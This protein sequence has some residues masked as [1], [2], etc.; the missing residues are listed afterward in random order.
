VG[1]FSRTPA[2]TH[3]LISPADLPGFDPFNAQALV[4]AAVALQST[5]EETG[6]RAMLPAW[7]RQA[8][9]FYDLLGEC[10]YPAQFYAR[11]LSRV[12]LY[13]GIEQT[14]GEIEED[15]NE[16][17][18]EI[19]A[20]ITGPWTEDYGQLQFLI[21][22]GNL[23][24]SLDDDGE[25]QWEY[26]S[27]AEFKR[28][29]KEKFERYVEPGAN[30]RDLKIVPP[31]AKKIG[32]GQ[33]IAYRLWTRHPMH[34]ALADSPVRAVLPRFQYLMLVDKAADAQA[35]SRIV[36]SGLLVVAEEI[37]L[38]GADSDSDPAGLD[39]DPFM[40]KLARHVMAPITNP[41]SVAQVA[42]FL[43]RI[44]IGDRSIDD[45]IKLIQL[46]DP[47][48]T[49]DWQQRI[50]KCITRIAIGL[51]MPPEEFLGLAEANHWTGW[52][53]SQSKW[54]AH[55]EPKTI[56]LCQDL[57]RV[58]FRK[59][60]R[61]A[62]IENWEKR[63]VWYDDAKV[64]THPDRGKD[65]DAVH[66]RGE[67]SGKSLRAAHDFNEKD[68]PS[69]AERRFF[70]A[71]K[72]KIPARPQDAPEEP[73]SDS[74]S[75]ADTDEPNQRG[76]RTENPSPMNDGQMAAL[77]AAG[78]MALE[79]CRRRAG[80]RV[81]QKR[82]SCEQCFK[83]MDDVPKYDLLARVG[84]DAVRAVGFDTDSGLCSGGAE[85]F[86]PTAMR[87]GLDEKSARLVAGQIEAFARDTLYEDAPVLPSVRL[88][89]AARAV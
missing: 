65:A 33:A 45:V 3:K 68:K 15:D 27:P 22:D 48:Q 84:V 20:R 30:P 83:G 19:L 47:N 58:Y 34:S 43:A 18:R 40:A 23:V 21:G 37:T 52:I 88:N 81:W 66:D 82:M 35:L 78:Q 29:G 50:E 32:A 38:P 76:Q 53:I 28:N 67:L 11:M 24:G 77:Q 14:N 8:M 75:D 62:G 2:P 57:S 72:L 26:L 7:Q 9:E 61:A 56:Q 16:G 31:D 54:Q 86:V 12:R 44:T 5:E 64:V 42:P 36:G 41:G 17:A 87:Y 6:F 85:T 25:E 69:P 74:G 1:L 51:D 71:V 59:A 70:E 13:S 73:V 10:W 63:V 80:N 79:E 39:G 49:A 4:A 89:G 46:H 55:G 60:C